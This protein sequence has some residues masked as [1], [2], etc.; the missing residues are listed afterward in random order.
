[1]RN[2]AVQADFSG[3]SVAQLLRRGRRRK[4]ADNTIK[5]RKRTNIIKPRAKIVTM[6][7]EQ[8]VIVPMLGGRYPQDQFRHGE[9]LHVSD[10]LYKCIRKIGISDYMNEAIHAETVWPGRALTFRFGHTVQDYLTELLKENEPGKLFGDWTCACG[11]THVEQKTWRQ[12]K[13]T[14]ECEKC[15]K[16]PDKYGEVIIRDDE[17]KVVG[18]IDLTLLMDEFFYLTEVKSIAAKGWQELNRPKPEHLL[19]VLF[20]WH[21]Y[22]RAGWPLWDRVSVIYVNKEFMFS[23]VPYKEFWFQPSIIEDRLDDL[24]SEARELVEYRASGLLPKRTMCQDKDSPDAKKCQFR[25][26]CFQLGG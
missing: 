11:H 21:L 12:I 9:Y 4:G 17:L 13:S 26:I 19:Q 6:S 25:D 14:Y 10:L 15:G 5:P 22:K 7:D 16:I 8:D 3:Q 18:S 24:L 1:M 23:G 20:Y 2:R